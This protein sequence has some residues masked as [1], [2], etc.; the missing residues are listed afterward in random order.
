MVAKSKSRKPAKRTPV[1]KPALPAMGPK[2]EFT[3]E[4][5]DHFGI[6]LHRIRALVAMA[7]IGVAAGDLGGW[8]EKPQ[9]LSQVYGDAWVYGDA[10]VSGNAGVSGSALVAGNA[11]VHGNA[12][13]YGDAWVYGDAQVYGD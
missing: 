11:R 4:T 8:V 10:R 2:Y 12:R 9:N 1:A 7:A 13:V 6:T 3:G 5:K